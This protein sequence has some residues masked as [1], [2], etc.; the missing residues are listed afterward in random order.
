MLLAFSDD[1]VEFK[2][3]IFIDEI[4]RNEYN[5]NLRSKLNI[6]SSKKIIGLWIGARGEKKWPL[7]NFIKLYQEIGKNINYSPLL[8]FGLEEE[9]DYHGSKLQSED[10]LLVI[11]LNEL[12]HIVSSLYCFICGDTGPLHLAFAAGV[13]AIGIFLKDN[14]NTYGYADGKF[15]FIIKHDSSENMINEILNCLEKIG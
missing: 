7:D 6:H 8:L 9:N 3:R 12:K 10:K 15:N 11:E 1:K 5:R 4:K 2:P 13:P 14:Y